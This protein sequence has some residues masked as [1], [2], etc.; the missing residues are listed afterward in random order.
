M[1]PKAE[2]H[3]S[4]AALRQRLSEQ[5][6]I[7]ESPQ[8]PNSDNE[9]RILRTIIPTDW[10]YG[11]VF[12]FDPELKETIESY[13][14][15]SLYPPIAKIFD[16][17]DFVIPQIDKIK[18][19]ELG[20]TEARLNALFLMTDPQRPVLSPE[21]P[22]WYVRFNL[23]VSDGGYFLHTELQLSLP[24]S[25]HTDWILEFLAEA[26]DW[27]ESPSVTTDR[28]EFVLGFSWGQGRSF[29]TLG[30]DWEN[31]LTEPFIKHIKIAQII[32][33]FSRQPEK[34][35]LRNKMLELIKT[36]YG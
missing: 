4:F 27:N 22:W 19:T 31:H 32:D 10:E 30:D 13:F 16:Q 14:C 12:L 25:I 5:T 29:P 11:T 18:L 9:P 6:Q 2:E 28:N 23:E 26:A 1:K 8:T 7:I 21:R 3:W 35:I 17:A 33:R 24:F 15:C 36:M 34:H 20:K